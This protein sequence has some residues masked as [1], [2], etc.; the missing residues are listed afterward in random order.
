MAPGAIPEHRR[1]ARLAE[2]IFSQLLFYR[3]VT[4]GG[5]ARFGLPQGHLVARQAVAV[6]ARTWRNAVVSPEPI[7]RLIRRISHRLGD[8][9]PL[10][11]RQTFSVFAIVGVDVDCPFAI[12]A[13]GAVKKQLVE[14]LTYSIDLSTLT[15]QVVI[16]FLHARKT[17]MKVRLVSWFC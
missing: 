14:C 3:A 9:A 1:P 17:N 10:S 4:H 12:A 13:I 7:R 2:D 15:A 6:M 5:A 11:G 8:S 16:V